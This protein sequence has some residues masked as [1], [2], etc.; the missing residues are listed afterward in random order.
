[1]G[2]AISHTLEAIVACDLMTRFAN[3]RAAFELER[4]ST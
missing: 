1:V 2:I 4:E 3:R